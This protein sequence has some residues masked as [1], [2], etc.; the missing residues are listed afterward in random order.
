MYF[1]CTKLKYYLIPCEVFIISQVNVIKYIFS[2]PMLHNR[3]GKWMLALTNFSF[4]FV[5][6]KVVKGQVLA[7]FFVNHLRL[8]IEE[9]N[10][11]ET[12]P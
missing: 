8:E 3:D 11:I 5:P 6:A 4:Y 7:N 12:K 10:L 2:S 9:V 1:S